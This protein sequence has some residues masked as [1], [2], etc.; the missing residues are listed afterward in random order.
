[1]V[2][3]QINTK[4]LLLMKI[5]LRNSPC[6]V[7]EYVLAGVCGRFVYSLGKVCGLWSCV[8]VTTA[9]RHHH[10]SCNISCPNMVVVGTLGH[11]TCYKLTTQHP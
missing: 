9:V 7:Y 11:V 4:D 8:S 5:N 1:M 10:G 2:I 6:I 3:N